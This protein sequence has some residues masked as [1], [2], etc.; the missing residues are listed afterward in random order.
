M[1]ETRSWNFRHELVQL[2]MQLFREDFQGLFAQQDLSVLEKKNLDIYLTDIKKIEEDTRK[3][4]AEIGG[5]ALDN[6]LQAGLKIED[7][8]LKAKS[9][10]SLFREAAE[11]REVKFTPS[12][13]E[14]LEQSVKWYNKDAARD[15]IEISEHV[16]M[17]FAKSDIHSAKSVKYKH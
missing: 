7:F 13:L 17:P 6:L 2:G 15:I 11:G 8:K 14:S 9:P 3:N 4:L 1:E 10:P 16:L 12:K 5:I